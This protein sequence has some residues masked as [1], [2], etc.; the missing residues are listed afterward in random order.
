LKVILD[1]SAPEG[2]GECLPGHDVHSATALGWKGIK[3]GKLLKL[4]ESIGTEAFI[5][6]DKSME[7]QQVFQ[8]RPFRTLIL[9][10]NSGPLIQ[11]HILDIAQAPE[12]AEIG[13]VTTVE[14]G[15]FVPSKFRRNPAS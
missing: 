9:S 12:T 5:T 1:E 11:D 14:C 2:L 4:L 3:N 8:G 13:V 15:R 7:K 6:S 10:T